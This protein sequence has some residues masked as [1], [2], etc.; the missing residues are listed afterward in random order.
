MK[1]ISPK[2]DRPWTP[3][4]FQAQ[5]SAVHEA[6]TLSH[7]SQP[8]HRHCPAECKDAR[9]DFGLFEA[10]VGVAKLGPRR[11]V[12]ALEIEGSNPSAHPKP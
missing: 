3:A 12:V 9:I 4:E 2:V 10:V 7:A 1:E 6:G 11:Q 5:R 8:A